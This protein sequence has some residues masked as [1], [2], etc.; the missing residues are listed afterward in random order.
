[1]TDL[2]KL[3]LMDYIDRMSYLFAQMKV[4]HEFAPIKVINTNS[5]YIHVSKKEDFDAIKEI[6]HIP[7][8]EV[9]I[10]AGIDGE[11][12]HYRFMVNDIE[13]SYVVLHI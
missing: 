8:D 5:A 6:Y 2:Q 7:D 13:I 10:S 1:M 9:K 3:N 4:C 11:S 12:T